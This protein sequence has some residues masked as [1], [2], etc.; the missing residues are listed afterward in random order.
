V[1]EIRYANG[2]G[3]LQSLST[4]LSSLERKQKYYEFLLS[5]AEET[6][7]EPTIN[8]QPN[9]VTKAG[10]IADELRKMRA[11][12]ARVTEHLKDADINLQPVDESMEGE[13]MDAQSWTELSVAI[14]RSERDEP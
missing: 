8:V 13:P 6:L 1:A 4:A 14:N 7:G 2:L 10:P 3:R 5:L 9:V 11:L 12:L